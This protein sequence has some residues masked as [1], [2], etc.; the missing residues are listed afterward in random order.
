MTSILLNLLSCIPDLQARRGH[1]FFQQFR[2]FELTIAIEKLRSAIGFNAP[3]IGGGALTVGG[4]LA[5]K[6]HHKLQGILQ[7]CLFSGIPDGLALPAMT[8]IETA[9]SDIQEGDPSQA[10]VNINSSWQVMELEDFMEGDNEEKT[11][12]DE[13]LFE[14][15]EIDTGLGIGMAVGAGGWM[16]SRIQNIR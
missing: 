10:G 12:L 7:N 8:P 1:H 2:P 13:L 15:I 16:G 11:E 6:S 4:A 9:L 5:E 14:G 3:A